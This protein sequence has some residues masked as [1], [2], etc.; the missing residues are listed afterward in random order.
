MR[1]NPDARFVLR[2]AER[3]H[4]AVRDGQ[5]VT[6]RRRR[7]GSVL[8]ADVQ[9]SQ[10]GQKRKASAVR[11]DEPVGRGRHANA[12]ATART[13][14]RHVEH[15]LHEQ[16]VAIPARLLTDDNSR[17]PVAPIVNRPVRLDVHQVADGVG[18]GVVLLPHEK[19]VA[20]QVQPPA[21]RH[22]TDVGR[23]VASHDQPS[24]HGG[25][26]VVRDLETVAGTHATVLCRTVQ[27]IR[28]QEDPVRGDKRRLIA[29]DHGV[30]AA[31]VADL[32]VARPFVA[33]E[34]TAGIRHEH[35]VVRG[36]VRVARERL[37]QRQ[38]LRRVRHDPRL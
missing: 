33:A 11:D 12:H 18:N 36:G 16:H 14:V 7:R 9:V 6:V 2:G 13:V 3:Q 30:V 34:G 15:P 38:E 20:P 17:R 28:R 25:R 10:I 8:S 19:H 35:Q 1:P 32:D 27:R 23:P 5:K 22:G 29:H 26:R 21:A 4:A 24:H 31:D 37:R